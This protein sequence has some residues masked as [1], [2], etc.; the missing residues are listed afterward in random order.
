MSRI[1]SLIRMLGSSNDNEALGAARALVRELTDNGAHLDDLAKAWEKAEAQRPP[2][3]ETKP[4]DYSK[5]ETAVTLYAQ[6]KAQVSMNKIIKAV[7]EMVTDTPSDDLVVRY[8]TARL[9]TLA[10]NLVGLETPT[11]VA[12][13]RNEL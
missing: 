8:I 13:G 1:P 2:P 5:V 4:F 12:S 7:G 6:D 10:S 9:R 3:Q 11:H